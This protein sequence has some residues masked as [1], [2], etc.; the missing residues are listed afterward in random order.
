MKR[1][2]IQYLW[3]YA[4][5]SIVLQMTVACS[6]ALVTPNDGDWALKQETLQNTPEAELMVRTGDIDNLRFGWPVNFNP[7]SGQNTPSHSYPWVPD[8]ADPS[9]TDRIMVISSY[10]GSPPFGKDGYTTNTSR[11]A[12]AVQPLNLVFT[13]PGSGVQNAVFQIF[14]DDF[15]A[16][17]W[18]SRFIA[19]LNGQPFPELATILNG[20]SQTGPVGKLITI[21]VPDV[22]LPA[23]SSGAVS[24]VI[25][26]LSTG[27]GDGYA[28]DFVKLLINRTGMLQVGTIQGQV[29]DAISGI[30]IAGATVKSFDKTITTNASGNYTLIEVPAGLAYVT[31]NAQGYAAAA[32]T[33]D[34]I[35]GQT[36][37]NFNFNLTRSPFALSIYP[38][39]E[40]EFF[41]H[42]GVSYILEYSS[43]MTN[44]FEDEQIV[45]TGVLV[46]RL[47]PTRPQDRRFWRVRRL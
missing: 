4:L 38:A 23:V 7:F 22:H 39:V 21:N 29:L 35:A 8:S 41:G 13:P 6:H 42:T 20:L 43:N 28:I 36:V 26:D 45:G 34:V 14:V 2:S 19:T 40:L 1:S 44:W 16:P 30:P 37:Q 31:A 33:V 17:V 10:T 24:L 18:R 27:A 5:T 3:R 32:R 25:D 12:N 47:R 46:S 9:G 11:P 15:Q